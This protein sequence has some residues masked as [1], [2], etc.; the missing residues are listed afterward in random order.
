CPPRPTLLRLD[1]ETAVLVLFAIKMDVRAAYHQLFSS[2]SIER[3]YLAVAGVSELPKQTT[4]RVENRLE[5]GEPW[6]RQR[7]VEGPVN[8]VT[9]IELIEKRNCSGLF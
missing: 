5:L 2:G 8:A 6:F 3:E 9:E 4:W 1:L 7:V